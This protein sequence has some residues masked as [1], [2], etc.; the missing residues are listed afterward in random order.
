MSY[1]IQGL[2]TLDQDVRLR[3]A[4]AAACEG[5]KDPTYWVDNHIWEISSIPGWAE[6]YKEALDTVPVKP[7][8]NESKVTDAM[9]LQAITQIL[10]EETIE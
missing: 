6:A 3:L 4:A 10:K 8:A 9:I 2:M 5:V 1:Y 7:G